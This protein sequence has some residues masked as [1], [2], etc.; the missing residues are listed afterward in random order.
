MNG[1]TLTWP[2]GEHTFALRLGELRAIQTN[3][4]SGPEEIWNS[5]RTGTWKADD[6]VQVIRFGLVGSGTMKADEAARF[7]TPLMDTSPL[8]QMKLTALAI[9]ANA[10]MGDLED[11]P[12]K[13]ET[14]D[15]PESGSSPTSTE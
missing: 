3:R 7:V 10:L 2:G 8:V 15:L 4:D 9:L 14:E 11:A 1:V 6:L 12:E 5:I 13:P